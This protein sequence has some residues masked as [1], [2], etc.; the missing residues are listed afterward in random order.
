MSVCLQAGL[1]FCLQHMQRQVAVAS[2]DSPAARLPSESLFLASRQAAEARV[3]RDPQAVPLPHQPRRSARLQQY[4]QP[5]PLAASNPA[6]VTVPLSG[7]AVSV[8]LTPEEDFSVGSETS[9]YS[10]YCGSPQE[11]LLRE[12]TPTW[13]T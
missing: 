6:S 2:P 12:L 3:K 8:R 11:G 5:D 13:G 10:D 7:R 9:S 4:P 1:Q